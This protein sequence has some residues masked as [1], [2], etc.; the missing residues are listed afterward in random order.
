MDCFGSNFVFSWLVT[1]STA[2]QEIL[3]VWDHVTEEFVPNKENNE[4]NEKAYWKL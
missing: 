4:Q 3:H 1:N 2:N